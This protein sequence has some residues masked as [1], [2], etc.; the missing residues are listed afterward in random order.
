MGIDDN[1]NAKPDRESNPGAQFRS[2]R[3]NHYTNWPADYSF[4]INE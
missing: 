2:H 4:K 1:G 3:V